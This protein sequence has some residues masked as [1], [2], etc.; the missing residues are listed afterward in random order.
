MRFLQTDH[1]VVIFDGNCDS[2]H[3]ILAA[4]GFCRPAGSKFLESFSCSAEED[5]PADLESAAFLF[6]MLV[7]DPESSGPRELRVL[8]PCDTATAFGLP[9]QLTSTDAPIHAGVF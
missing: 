3:K 8:G 9:L 6:H 7:G 2:R 4:D 5:A 1:F